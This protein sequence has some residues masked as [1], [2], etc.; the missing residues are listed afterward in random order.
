MPDPCRIIGVIVD[1]GETP[2][3]KSAKL[4]HE[5]TR[6]ASSPRPTLRRRA[7]GRAGK[8]ADT[9]GGTWPSSAL[10]EGP[11]AEAPWRRRPRGEGRSP[12]LPSVPARVG[13]CDIRYHDGLELADMPPSSSATDCSFLTKE[14]LLSFMARSGP[15]PYRSVSNDNGT[16]GRVKAQVQGEMGGLSP[17]RREDD[18]GDRGWLCPR[19]RIARS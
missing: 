13:E 12:A 16:A 10:R 5:P 18:V 9:P 8:G 14:F 11:R 4:L 3:S 6:D 17:E 1:A 15:C 19:A 7:R 2:R